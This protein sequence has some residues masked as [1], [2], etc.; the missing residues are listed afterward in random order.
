MPASSTKKRPPMEMEAGPDEIREGEDDK[1]M[2]FAKGKS[3]R[4]RSAKGA[5]QTKAP[6][7]GGMYGKKPM[8]GEGCN[9]GK[10]KA[11]CDGSCGK[12]MDRNDA[13]TPQEYL[14][15]CD[16]GVQ[17]RP[18]SYIRA[19]LDAA[20]RIDQKCGA[21]GIADNK[22][23]RIGSGGAPGQ[24]G[25]M[26]QRALTASK[27]VKSNNVLGTLAAAGVIGGAIGVANHIET[28]ERKGKKA[29]EVIKKI[30]DIK[31]KANSG[32]TASA[33]AAKNSVEFSRTAKN[34]LLSGPAAEQR[35]IAQGM[36]RIGE[37]QQTRA[38]VYGMAKQ[39]LRELGETVPA[40]PARR[41]R[42][43][44]ARRARSAPGGALAT[45]DTYADGFSVD[46]AALNV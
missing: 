1:E 32:V 20:E 42:A 4:K 16:L 27:S 10:R 9:C 30:K 26:E 37:A 5:K 11:K 15:A 43:S 17:N 13:L 31:F 7:D 34:P 2:P 14:A 33:L 19:R 8:D 24:G 36:A 22:K 18:R 6:M 21:S 25:S 23:C 28:Q 38:A 35:A 40:S 46:T 12:K 45:R 41:R 44:A 29:K 39:T 3:S